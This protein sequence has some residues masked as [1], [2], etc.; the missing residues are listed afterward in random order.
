MKRGLKFKGTKI[1]ASG[2]VVNQ[3]VKLPDWVKCYVCGKRPT[4]MDWLK[5]VNPDPHCRK[6]IHLSH[7]PNHPE[8]SLE[9]GYIA[10]NA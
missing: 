9:A 7:I 1:D 8:L 6:F 3:D 5:P 4:A 2:Y 10:R